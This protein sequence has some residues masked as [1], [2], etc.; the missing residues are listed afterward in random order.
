[1][2]FIHRLAEMFL[3][4]PAPPNDERS[5]KAVQ[6]EEVRQEVGKALN[7]VDRIVEPEHGRFA[8]YARVR[9]HR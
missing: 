6:L 1:V 8:S 9:V 4:R 5:S 7:R 3:H 2:S